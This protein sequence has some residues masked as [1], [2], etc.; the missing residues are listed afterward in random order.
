MVTEPRAPPVS[1][2]IPWYNNLAQARRCVDSV[3]AQTCGDFILT[4]LDDGAS[5]EY[6][7]YVQALGDPRVRYHRNPERL[8]SMRNMFQAIVAG[9][10]AYTLAFHEDDL[11]GRQFLAA[12]V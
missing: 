5:D 2:N 10:G 6:R 9:S 4:L 7:D 11:L 12:A 8:G 1:I 3:L